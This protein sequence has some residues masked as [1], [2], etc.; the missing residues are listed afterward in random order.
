M[1]V[2]EQEGFEPSEEEDGKLNAFSFH[3]WTSGFPEI[4]PFNPETTRRAHD[5]NV[6]VFYYQKGLCTD[7][8]RVVRSACLSLFDYS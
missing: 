1:S 6:R 8:Y 7:W 4:I 3:F 2:R 5:S